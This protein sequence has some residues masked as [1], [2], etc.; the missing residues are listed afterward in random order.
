VV[1]CRHARART[2]PAPRRRTPRAAA[3]SRTRSPAKGPRSARRLAPSAWHLPRAPAIGDHVC[4]RVIWRRSPARTTQLPSRSARRPQ[5][6]RRKAARSCRRSSTPTWPSHRR[7]SHLHVFSALYI[8]VMVIYSEYAGARENDFT[9]S[10]PGDYTPSGTIS[11]AHSPSGRGR[12][13]H[14][15][16]PRSVAHIR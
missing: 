1:Q 10:P 8:S 11:K 16:P 3:S 15:A 4:R 14:H 5:L 13:Q 6:E 2:R 12:C 7:Q 9:R